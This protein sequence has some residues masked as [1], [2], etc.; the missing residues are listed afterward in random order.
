MSKEKVSATDSMRLV[1]ED[2]VKCGEGSWSPC[3]NR[4]SAIKEKECCNLYEC[5]YQAFD[6]DDHFG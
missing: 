1:P 3:R 4:K 6:P 2:G 5:P